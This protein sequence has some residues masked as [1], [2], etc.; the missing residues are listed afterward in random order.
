MDEKRNKADMFTTD[1]FLLSLLKIKLLTS[2]I[3]STVSLLVK[4]MSRKTIKVY[5]NKYS[6]IMFSI[7][8]KLAVT[9]KS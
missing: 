3:F 8:S 2:H 6:D 7:L 5:F 9:H 4:K 1:H